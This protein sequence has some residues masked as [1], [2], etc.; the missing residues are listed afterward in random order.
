MEDKIIS[1]LKNINKNL[2]NSGG[3]SSTINPEEMIPLEIPHTD[4]IYYRTHVN[5]ATS[6]SVDSNNGTIASNTYSDKGVVYIDNGEDILTNVSGS[7]L[8]LQYNNLVSELS[9]SDEVTRI[10]LPKNIKSVKGP[11]QSLYSDSLCKRRKITI[12]SLTK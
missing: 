11:L 9:F 6:V 2:D 10:R 7:T 1:I 5:D 3:N 4:T 8:S 12:F